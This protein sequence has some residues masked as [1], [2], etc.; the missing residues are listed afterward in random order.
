MNTSTTSAADAAVDF[1]AVDWGEVVSMDTKERLQQRERQRLCVHV[2]LYSSLS[3]LP[4]LLRNPSEKSPRPGAS[5]DTTATGEDS[6][7]AVMTD[8]V[9]THDPVGTRRADLCCSWC[10]CCCGRRMSIEGQQSQEGNSQ[11]LSGP[12][13]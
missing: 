1:G 9:G 13:S 5:T 6:V 8:L 2:L 10:R 3:L 7:K 12:P 11:H 4:L